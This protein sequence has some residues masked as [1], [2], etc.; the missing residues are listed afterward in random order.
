MT[1]KSA[2][3]RVRAGR[4][5]REQAEARHQELLDAALDLFLEHG[6]EVTTIEMIAARVSMTK[7]TIYA[8]HPDKA[9]L[10]RTAIQRAIERQIVPPHVLEALER[11]KLGATLEA[12]AWLRIE[13]IA[14]PHG[15][16]LQHLIN[17]ESHRFPEIFT[18]YVEQS[19]RPLID[20]VA[21]V[22][23]RAVDAGEIAPTRVDHAASAFMSMV[24]GGPV[25]AIVGGLAPTRQELDEKVGFTVRLLLDGLRPR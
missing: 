9:T 17:A 25:R 3:P 16:R 23:Q 15:L 5:T 24:V 22:L 8:R 14:A 2:P 7:R 19:T 13:Q 12:I 20:H 6:F 11:G 10:F 4:P 1:D 21:A 18:A